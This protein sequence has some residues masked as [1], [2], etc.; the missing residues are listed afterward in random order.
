MD[1]KGYCVLWPRVHTQNKG[2]LRT[3]KN[4]SCGYYS[5]S[6]GRESHYL[7][8]GFYPLRTCFQCYW[9]LSEL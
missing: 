8:R 5:T 4:E 6:S 2:P 7:A 1:K 3:V 9:Y